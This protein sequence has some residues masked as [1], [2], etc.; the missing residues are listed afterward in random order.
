[1]VEQLK[2]VGVMVAGYQK[3]TKALRRGKS[4]FDAM[5]PTGSVAVIVAWYEISDC[6][7]PA[8][9]YRVKAGPPHILAWSD[10]LRDVFP[11]M[12]QAATAYD[13]TGH[14]RHSNPIFE[15]RRKYTGGHGLGYFLKGGG[16]YDTAWVIRKWPIGKW[17]M[18]PICLAL[19]KGRFHFSYDENRMITDNEQKS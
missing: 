7:P 3:R 14:L 10:Y 11:E 17:S 13:R 8:D 1:M 18:D 6:D 4:M 12:R 19:A 2:E 15:Y 16:L 9:V 5:R